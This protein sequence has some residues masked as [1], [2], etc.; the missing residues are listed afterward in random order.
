MPR[1]VV[2]VV[3]FSDTVGPQDYNIDLSRKLRDT[4]ERYLVTQRVPLHGG[5]YGRTRR[6]SSAFGIGSGQ[7][8][9]YQ[10]E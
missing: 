8:F 5:P 4:V 1:V 9:E 6:R 7:Q 2:E 10:Q 3:G